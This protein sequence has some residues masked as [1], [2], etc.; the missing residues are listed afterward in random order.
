MLKK[1]IKKSLLETKDKKDKSLIE[2][3]LIRSRFSFLLEDILYT[4]I[5]KKNQLVH[6]MRFY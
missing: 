3:N 6:R 2:E 5:F 1:Q 4:I